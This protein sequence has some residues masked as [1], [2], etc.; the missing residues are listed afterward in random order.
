AAN[1]E[2]FRDE[3]TGHYEGHQSELAAILEAAR[4]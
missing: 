4:G 2:F 1:M 3:T